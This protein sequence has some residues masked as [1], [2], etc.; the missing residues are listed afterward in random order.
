MHDKNYDGIKINTI[1]IKYFIY[2]LI[3]TTIN[4]VSS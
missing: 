4:K 2:M 3:I 1:T